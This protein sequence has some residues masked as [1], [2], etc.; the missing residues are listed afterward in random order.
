M[1]RVSRA[2][3]V[4]SKATIAVALLL[5]LGFGAYLFATYL[6]QTFGTLVDREFVTETRHTFQVQLGLDEDWHVRTM[7][8]DPD[9]E[10]EVSLVGRPYVGYR[11]QRVGPIA[12]VYN[13]TAILR[14]PGTFGQYE[15][16]IK[17]PWSPSGDRWFFELVLEG[18]G[19]LQVT[20]T[21]FDRA[22]F[23]VLSLAVAGTASVL[24]LS[25]WQMARRRRLSEGLKRNESE[26]DEAR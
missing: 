15:F 7:T 26:G 25:V 14:D 19:T 23:V 24:A 9:T 10:Y 17:V 22:G 8:T 18:Y 6:P 1:R 2:G 20:I 5:S 4:P 12:F 21:K 3:R 13:W 16:N 11:Q